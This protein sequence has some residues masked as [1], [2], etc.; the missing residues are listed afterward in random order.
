MTKLAP[1]ALSVGF[2][3]PR[4]GG[5]GRPR[6]RMNEGL[7]IG[8][9]SLTVV[10][11][12]LLHPAGPGNTSPVDL[13]VLLTL[14]MTALWASTS[15]LPLRAPYVVPVA[16]S[17]LAGT[18][19]ALASSMP[20]SG[21]LA[22]IQDM[23]LLAWCTAI[24]NLARSPG[25]LRT[26]GRAWAISS[27]CWAGVLVTASL[28]HISAL[29]GI[30]PQDGNRLIFTFGD[31]NYAGAY[32]VISLFVVYATRAP[33]RT[34]LR[35]V[36]YLLLS[37]SFVLSESNGAAV[38]LMAGV[39]LIVCVGIYRKHGLVNAIAL[40]VTAVV[41]V[42]I[43]LQVIPIATVQTWARDSGQS[44]LVNTLGRSNG[45][46]AQ[47]GALIDEALS[48]YASNSLLGSGPSTTKALLLER[49]YPYAKEA[50]DDY[51][52]ALV[53]R[54]PLGVI[55]V[56]LLVF[57]AAWRAKTVLRGPPS[58]DFAAQIP[59][60]VGLVAA[61]AAMGVA[62]AYYEVMH[63][64]F[65]WLLLA[66]VAVLASGPEPQPHADENGLGR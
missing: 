48:L 36:G 7:A 59:R 3:T 38:E 52:A 63:F 46:S 26:I 50:H 58:P 57:S 19:A 61:L 49:Q 25:A 40:L 20:M 54:G 21:L 8:V 33:N 18:L 42:V 29:E 5:A 6:L 62:G 43:V 9:L 44:L 47:R 56:V 28:L 45:S 17:V 37:W 24:V 23:V 65:L 27:I 64:R 16:V 34:W 41:A 66:L 31:P 30:R 10:C 1:T 15:G 14:L 4:T 35:R 60:P 13:L 51:L 32:W 12:P 55:G 53:E 22:V 11:Q 39:G 2:E